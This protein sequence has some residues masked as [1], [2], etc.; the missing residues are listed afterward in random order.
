MPN[1]DSDF[2]TNNPVN[3][4]DLDKE[5][6]VPG[7]DNDS[8]GFRD[9]FTVID[10]NF[11][12]TKARLEDL[13]TNAVRIET[14]NTFLP[15]S[16]GGT[17]RLINP[18]LQ[19]H[20]EFKGEVTVT[21]GVARIDFSQGSFQTLNLT[22]ATE[23][24]INVDTVPDSG[25]MQK[26]TLSITASTA[27]QTL[28]WDNTQTFKFDRANSENFWGALPAAPESDITTNE[29]HI[30]DVWTYQGSLTFFV[31]YIGTFA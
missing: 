16:T 11:V 20:S 25:Y 6:P 8:Q 29:T 13:E 2:Y 10:D 7:Q 19:S 31:K 14:N 5:F 21:S 26:V 4:T 12:S 24:T 3:V 1:P 17:A 22:E 15:L 30:V 23:I 27:T 18:T 28:T 9:N